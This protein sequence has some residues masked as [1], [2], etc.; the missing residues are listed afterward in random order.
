[1]S[2]T[3]DEFKLIGIMTFY[4]ILQ[5][6][7]PLFLIAMSVW[8]ISQDFFEMSEWGPLILLA[9][10]AWTV[11]EIVKF[12]KWNGFTVTVTDEDI[13]VKGERVAWSDV[14]TAKVQFAMK[15][16]TWIEI[17]PKGGEVLKIPAAINKKDQLLTLVEKH[18]PQ[19]V[20]S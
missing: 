6:L 1:V 16:D 15:F 10:G 17:Q 3:R 20:K 5:I 7:F 9:F 18:H 12:I 2:G 4:M 8:M 13:T 19:L 11:W 14:E